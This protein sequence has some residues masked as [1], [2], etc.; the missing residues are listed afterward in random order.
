MGDTA[1]NIP[2]APGVGPKTAMKLVS[3]YGSVEEVFRNTDKL[4]GKLKEIIENNKEQIELSK[5]LATIELNVPVDLKEDELVLETPDRNK[6]KSL[7]NELEFRTIAADI[8]P[9]IDKEARQ[10]ET[11]SLLMPSFESTQGTLFGNNQDYVPTDK[12]TIST[13]PHNYFL[14]ENEKELG[15]FVSRAIQ[16]KEI[17]F[18]TETTSINP[19]DSELVAIAFSW[20]KGSG[21]LVHFSESQETTRE[22]L[23]ILKP[24]FENP[25]IVKIGQNMKFDIQVLANYG[26]EVK[27][28]L[29]DTMIAHYLLEPDMR[30]NMNL[31]SET[32]LSYSPVHIESLIGEKGNN[33]KNMRSVPVEQIKEYA[34]ED[35]D[36]TF[37]LKEGS[38]SAQIK[39]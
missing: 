23:K 22:K 10:S 14:I 29:F 11:E 3:E 26:L 28:P 5:K 33:Q 6:L 34:V 39:I 18:D 1:D 17:C 31:L 16:L 19:L 32:Y 21:Y 30:H 9:E 24:I 8:L 25:A 36:V 15:E 20:E 13:V 38:V 12:K 7:F 2:G 35:A 37:Q 4:K 27:G